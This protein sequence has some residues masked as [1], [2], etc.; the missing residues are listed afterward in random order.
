MSWSIWS[1]LFRSELERTI[2]H[3]ITAEL[4]KNTDSVLARFRRQ[5]DL[6]QE[7]LA[8]KTVVEDLKIESARIR[9]THAREKREIEHML[10]LERKRQEFDLAASKRETT[11]A[12]REEALKADRERFVGQMKFHEDRFVQEVGYLK[13]LLK[14]TLQ[15][16]PT[17]TM[18][19]QRIVTERDGD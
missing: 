16:L 8:L 14:Q 11:V 5:A 1:I 12:I 2:E 7:S 17:A 19:T 6:E 4:E 3:A 9:E 15:A 18:V 13:D 10:G